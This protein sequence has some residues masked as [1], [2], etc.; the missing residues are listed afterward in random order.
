M[1][2]IKLSTADIKP[3]TVPFTNRLI[4]DRWHPCEMHRPIQAEVQGSVPAAFPLPSTIENGYLAADNPIRPVE[5]FDRYS[6]A[7]DTLLNL[8]KNRRATHQTDRNS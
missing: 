8:A 3:T 1:Y 7:E 6:K 2:S 4:P 5:M